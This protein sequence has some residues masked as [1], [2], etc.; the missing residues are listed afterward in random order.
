MAGWDKIPDK[1]KFAPNHPLEAEDETRR[2]TCVCARRLRRARFHRS[3][4]LG[5]GLGLSRLRPPNLR[6]L[7]RKRR[8]RL[9]RRYWRADRRRPPRPSCCRVHG[10]FRNPWPRSRKVSPT[11]PL[12]SLVA[13]PPRDRHLEHQG[14]RSSTRSS[15]AMTGFP[16]RSRSTMKTSRRQ[17][18]ASATTFPKQWF[19]ATQEERA[20]AYRDLC[21]RRLEQSCHRA[22]P[23]QD[24]GPLV[25]KERDLPD[26]R[27]MAI[28]LLGLDRQHCQP[29]SPMACCSACAIAGWPPSST[30]SPRRV[31]ALIE[32]AA[33]A[34][35]GRCGAR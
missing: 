30:P 13:T 17:S 27:R 25:R 34:A 32:V 19:E 2:R 24:H 8:R 10:P 9:G 29:T 1:A 21:P 18:S 28:G 16:T 23:H 14:R 33:I 4:L 22:E 26:L 3:K 5:P 20:Q 11:V 35:A 15:S 12:T 31:T 6:R 7:A